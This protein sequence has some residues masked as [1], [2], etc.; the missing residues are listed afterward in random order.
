[1]TKIQ[2]IKTIHK[3]SELRYVDVE[4]VVNQLFDIISDSIAEEEKVVISGFGTFEKIYQTSYSGV[5]P[6]TGEKITVEG[7]NKVRFT[8]SRVLRD[9]IN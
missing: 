1:M 6:S 7:F 3:N 2:I 8:S 9:K 5:N 4:E